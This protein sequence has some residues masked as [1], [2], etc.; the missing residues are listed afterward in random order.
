MNRS[1]VLGSRSPARRAILKILL[2]TRLPREP[3]ARTA[4]GIFKRGHSQTY[5]AQMPCGT[6]SLPSLPSEISNL[7]FLP[8]PTP[9]NR[10]APL[11]EN[12]VPPDSR[13]SLCP[14]RSKTPHF[15]VPLLYRQAETIISPKTKPCIHSALSHSKLQKTPRIIASCSHTMEKNRG[16]AHPFPSS[17]PQSSCQIIA[18]C[19]F[20][21]QGEP[22]QTHRIPLLSWPSVPPLYR[23]PG[24]TCPPKLLG[25]D[26]TRKL[27]RDAS[28][29]LPARCYTL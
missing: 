4:T 5:T 19:V 22:A 2:Q 29:R 12:L 14:L 11:A 1:I 15:P 20:A 16:K 7:K 8:S 17:R 6:V 28:L 24:K 13:P 21:F 9:G 18:H 23:E 25:A 3:P 10:F 27:A 26:R